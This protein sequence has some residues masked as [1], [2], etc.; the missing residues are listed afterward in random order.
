M[1]KTATEAEA[2][3]EMRGCPAGIEQLPSVA[4]GGHSYRKRLLTE[5]SQ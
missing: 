1:A 5:S 2:E 3:I 4:I